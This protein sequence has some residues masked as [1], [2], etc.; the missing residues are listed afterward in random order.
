MVGSIN[1]FSAIEEVNPPIITAAIGPI[2]SRP[3]L[4]LFMAMGNNAK[5]VTR[6]VIRIDVNLSCAPRSAVSAFQR[7]SS[8]STK[9][10]WCVV[11]TPQCVALPSSVRRLLVHQR[12]EF[13]YA[14]RRTLGHHCRLLWFGHHGSKPVGRQKYASLLRMKVY[15]VTAPPIATR[16]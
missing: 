11:V 13:W 10:R 3:G 12:I 14:C 4:S 16:L 15:L 9:C 7:V 5:A 2:I 8:T 1:K 6:A